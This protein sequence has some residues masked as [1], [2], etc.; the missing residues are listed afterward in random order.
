MSLNLESPDQTARPYL[1][2]RNVHDEPS[3][4]ILF[5]K[6]TDIA[7]WSFHRAMA[8]GHP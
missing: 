4:G 3:V 7:D 5:P 6:G 1:R 2:P 8:F